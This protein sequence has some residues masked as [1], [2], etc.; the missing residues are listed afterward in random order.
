MLGLHGT[1]LCNMV[2]NIPELN[3]LAESETAPESS[4]NVS[5]FRYEDMHI[6]TMMTFSLGVSWQRVR[7]PAKDAD[8]NSY[9]CLEEQVPCSLHL[10]FANNPKGYSRPYSVDGAVGLILATGMVGHNLDI[11]AGAD[12]VNT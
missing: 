10:F 11:M 2:E 7:A 3:A 6:V 4:T 8:G 1:F 5:E 12:R 9:D